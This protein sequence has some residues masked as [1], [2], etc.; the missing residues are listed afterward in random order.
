MGT[1][2]DTEQGPTLLNPA[3]EMGSEL[4]DGGARRTLS[5]REVRKSQAGEKS[6]KPE[7][8]GTCWDSTSL[9]P[10]SAGGG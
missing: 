6:I 3:P 7:S 4:E 1:Q 8:K 9:Q 5:P 10:C 2:L